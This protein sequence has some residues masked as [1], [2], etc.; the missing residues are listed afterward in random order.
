MRVKLRLSSNVKGLPPTTGPAWFS[1]RPSG[2]AP[3]VVCPEQ[4][5]SR[6]KPAL[7]PGLAKC[8]Y[9][10]PLKKNQTQSSLGDWTLEYSSKG[11]KQKLSE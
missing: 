5:E 11:E 3:P 4:P 6:E 2:R 1:E 8:C 9:C 10:F 7:A